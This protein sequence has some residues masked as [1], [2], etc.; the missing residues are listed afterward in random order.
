TNMLFGECPVA[1]F[2]VLSTEQ[3]KHPR[4]GRG[5]PQRPPE[6]MSASCRVNPSGNVIDE[7]ALVRVRLPHGG[8]LLL[9][10]QVGVSQ[11]CRPIR[12]G[13]AVSSGA[14]SLCGGL[15]CKPKHPMSI[16]CA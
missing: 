16:V 12:G 10:E 9:R 6:L 5:I 1:G 2:P 11:C 13:L 3:Q 4:H 7:M 15:G 8:F 14:G